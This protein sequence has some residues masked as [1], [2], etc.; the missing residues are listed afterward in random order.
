MSRV[1]KRLLFIV[2]LG[3]KVSLADFLARA[4]SAPS[5]LLFDE[6]AKGED[7]GGKMKEFKSWKSSS[8]RYTLSY[9]K[10]DR[11]LVAFALVGMPSTDGKPVV[12]GHGLFGVDVTWIQTSVG[13]IAIVDHKISGGL[14]ELFVVK[15]SNR[16]NWV[17]LY[18]TPNPL[19]PNGLAMDHCYWSVISMDA[20]AGSLRLKA[21]WSFSNMSNA[22]RKAAVT[23]GVYEIPLFYGLRVIGRAGESA[24]PKR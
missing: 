22:A 19:A 13:E 3:I 1:A 4:D 24:K 14:N 17:L 10:A 5:V 6:W 9:L 2:L 7:G 18:R 11:D 12:L 23:E 8:G 16:G 20:D 15:P 21:A